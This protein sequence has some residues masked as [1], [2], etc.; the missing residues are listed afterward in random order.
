MQ[1]VPNDNDV[2]RA[3]F[4]G[5]ANRNLGVLSFMVDMGF[6]SFF[7][8]IETRLKGVVA[9]RFDEG[10]DSTFDI[11]EDL[12]KEENREVILKFYPRKR[13]ALSPY[14]VDVWLPSKGVLLNKWLIDEGKANQYI[15]KEERE[16]DGNK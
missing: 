7:T 1:R 13:K 6:D 16:P 4:D 12:M 15:R 10:E 3:V 2:R 14:L 9:I 8:T 5:V 11:I